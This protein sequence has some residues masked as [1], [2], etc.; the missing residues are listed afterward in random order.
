[1][2]VRADDRVRS[3]RGESCKPEEFESFLVE[4][5]ELKVETVCLSGQVNKIE[6]NPNALGGLKIGL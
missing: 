1:M 6:L 5:F 4:T 3:H 2:C